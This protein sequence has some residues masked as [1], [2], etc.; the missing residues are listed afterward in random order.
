MTSNPITPSIPSNSP[1]MRMLR[2]ILRNRSAQFGGLLLL[3]LIVVSFAAPLLTSFDPNKNAPSQALQPPGMEHLMGTDNLGRDTLTRF[4]YGGQLSLRIGLS[5][6]FIGA[7][8]G[9]ALGLISGYFGGWLDSFLS[10]FNDVLMA[11]PDILLA[12]AII[13]ILGPGINNAMLAIG[14]SFIPSFMR[15]TRSSVLALREMTYIEAARA[16]GSSDSRILVR[17]ILPN[18]IRTLLVLLTLGIGSSILA[19]AALN[20]LGLGAEPPTAE[21]GAMLNAGMKYVRNAWWLT[22]FPGFGIF[23]AVLSINLIGDAVSDAVAGTT[24]MREGI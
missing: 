15:L 16:L 9:I 10:W 17:H 19:G 6:I 18:S 14:I 23:L 8:I 12:L 3:M 11:F 4:L 7:L 5:G 22:F 21:W 24:I 20:F 13:A 2:Q 1:G